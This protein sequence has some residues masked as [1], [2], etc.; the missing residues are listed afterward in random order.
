MKTLNRM[1]DI[2]LYFI[3]AAVLAAVVSS[4]IWDRPVLFSAVRSDSMTPLFGRGDVVFVRQLDEDDPVSAG[5]IVLFKAEAGELSLHGYIAHRIIGGNREEGYTTKGDANDYSDQEAGNPPVKRAWIVSRISAAE[6]RPARI[7][8]LGYLSI[9]AE[10]VKSSRYTLPAI[11]ILLIGVL[12]IGE[13]KNSGKRK[14]GKTEKTGLQQLYFFSGLTISI[15][16]ATL[17]LAS[18][19]RITFIYEVAENGQGAIMG[20]SV[21]I[22]NIG[23]ERQLMLANIRNNGVIPLTAVITTDDRQLSFSHD[24]ATLEKGDSITPQ[25]FLK[26]RDVGNYSSTINI[27]VFYPFIP[28]E[29]IRFLANISYWLAL[30]AVALLPGLPLMIYPVV[31][32]TMRRQTLKKIRRNFRLAQNRLPAH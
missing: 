7:P 14:P 4:I 17:M 5:D 23:D 26:A 21:G 27:G 18:S 8:I 29:S 31:N 22:V 16:L 15:I 19:Q 13:L 24:L 25:V 20:S 3:A 9:G 12:G 6:D 28:R 1:I 30:A 32:R 11:A 2:V 10:S